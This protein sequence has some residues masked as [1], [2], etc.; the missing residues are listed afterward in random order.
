MNA[1]SE[2]PPGNPGNAGRAES[3]QGATADVRIS[4]KVSDLIFSPGA[5]AD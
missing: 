3:G 5:A 4:D 2:P 1:I